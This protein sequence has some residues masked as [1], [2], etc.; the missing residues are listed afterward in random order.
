MH[1]ALLALLLAGPA[2]CEARAAPPGYDRPTARPGHPGHLA[3][4]HAAACGVPAAEVACPAGGWAGDGFCPP[5]ERVWPVLHRAADLAIVGASPVAPYKLAVLMPAGGPDG[6]A[7]DWDVTPETADVRETGD[8]GIV[9]TGPPGEYRVTLRAFTVEG[10]KVGTAKVRRTVTLGGAPPPQPPGPG[11]NPPGPPTPPTPPNPAVPPSDVFRVL[12]VYESGDL[13]KL[14]AGQQGAVYSSAV[15]GYLNAKTPVGPDGKTR[16]WA[17]LD[18]DVDPSG[19]G[20]WFAE[21]MRAPRASLPWVVVGSPSGGYA[22]PL[23]ATA[24]ATLELLKKYGGP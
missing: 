17:M 11:P 2:P 10:G 13:S 4:P 1:A 21:A 7:Y 12:V 20:P 8:G 22:G 24:D 9:F 15:R 5:P 18:K 6:A 19:Y 14:P 16:Q 3:G 23:P